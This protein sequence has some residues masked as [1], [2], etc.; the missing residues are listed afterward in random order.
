MK[1]FVIEE[2]YPEFNNLYG[3]RGN[4]EYL[5]KKLTAA[6]YETEVVETTLFDEPSFV[7]GG[8]DILLIGPTGEKRPDLRKLNA[9]KNIRRL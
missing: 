4:R 9:L 1:K 5:V 2:L 7:R 3:D 6:G 8:V